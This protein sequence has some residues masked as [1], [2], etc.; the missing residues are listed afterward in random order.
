MKSRTLFLAGLLSLCLVGAASAQQTTVEG[1]VVSNSGGTLVVTTAE[2]QRTFLV[3]GQS[4]V[5]ASL[6][7][8][9]RVTIEYQTTSDNQMHAFKV[10][11][12]GAGTTPS[13][14]TGST[15]PGSTTG[16]MTGTTPTGTNDDLSRPDAT[17]RRTD[18]NATGTASTATRPATTPSGTS[19]TDTTTTTTSP[20]TASTQRTTTPSTSATDTTT[21]TPMTADTSSDRLPAT[22]S[23]LP[24][25]ALAG[26]L[27][28]ATGLALRRLHA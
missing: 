19:M 6:A 1:T 12:V 3:D 25:I 22:A 17:T 9:T 10:S 16:S 28:L 27:A 23:P 4:S 11:P 2:G 8:G 13:G 26:T 5:P 20:S 7:T 21:S 14:S 24:L 15:T 18:S